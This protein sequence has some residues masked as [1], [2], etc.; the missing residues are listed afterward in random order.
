MDVSEL[1]GRI[2]DQRFEGYT[3]TGIATE[4]TRFHAGDG[5]GSIGTAVD[6]LKAVAKALV[7][8]DETLRRELGKLGVEWQ[9]EAGGQAGQVMSEQAGFSHD[10]NT[11]VDHSAE[12][13]FAQGE[14]FNRTLYKL[15]DAETVRKGAG[16]F[17]LGDGLASL[18]GFETDHAKD[19]I[20][21]KD[22]RAQALEAL[23]AYAAQSGEN[24]LSSESIAAPQTMKLTES[25]PGSGALDIA[26]TAVEVTPDGST[27]PASASVQSHYVEPPRPVIH[28]TAPPVASH[29][30]P[31]PSYG[32]ASQGRRTAAAPTPPSAPTTPASAPTNPAGATR[33]APAGWVQAPG[34]GPSAHRPEPG[35]PSGGQPFVPPGAPGGGSAAVPPGGSVGGRPIGTPIP[36]NATGVDGSPGRGSGSSSSFEGGSASGSRGGTGGGVAAVGGEQPLAKGRLTGAGPQAPVTPGEVGRSFPAVPKAGVGPGDIGAGA[37]AV[38]AG[39]IGGALSG[40]TE[41]QK[42]GP[43]AGKGPVRPLPVGELPEEEAIALRKSEQISPK[44]PKNDPKFMEHAAPQDA[45]ETD[46][47]AEHIRRFGVDDQD[48]FADQRMVSPDLI[49]DEDAGEVR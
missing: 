14:A 8:T 23:N 6:A 21:A 22:A 10:A 9:S 31:T 44:Q 3:D 27:R 41:R 1:A 36:G 15:P 30:T 24:L 2:R 33:P 49:G 20:A 19:V 11:K 18:I 48:L 16:G 32:I 43:S 12:M 45:S 42:R 7:D 28:H 25:G 13:I 46:E 35:R 37:A 29:D 34:R 40:D 5:I 4:I 39:G 38:G 26:G 17:T 47:D